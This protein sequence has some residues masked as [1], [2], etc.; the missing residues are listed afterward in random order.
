MEWK[1]RRSAGGAVGVAAIAFLLIIAMW[2]TLTA[3]N[4]PV[5]LSSFLVVVLTILSL[6]LAAW[7]GYLV[8]GYF[9]LR[10][11]LDRNA[12]IIRWA[13]SKQIIPLDQIV[14]TRK[15]REL[16]NRISK[17][18][19]FRW[20]GYMVGLGRISGVGNT[21]FY[22]TSPLR[23]Q[24]IISTSSLNYAI[25]PPD[26]EG[27]LSDLDSYRRVGTLRPL[28]EKSER[29]AF[30]DHPFWRDRTAHSLI[31]LGILVNALLFAYISWRYRGLPDLLP[32]HF[33]SQGVADIISPRDEI[34]RIPTAGLLILCV[35]LAIG[36][37][38]HRRE[39]PAAYILFGAIVATQVLL[40]IPILHTV[41]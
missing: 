18:P 7:V 33:D 8:Y 34:F 20:W 40:L 28:N 32:L 10:Y 29:S 6:S 3:L 1:P 27:F 30:A 13:S 4:N 14:E 37:L 31:G 22:A 39:R 2:F 38:A 36:A 23:G 41:H 26:I 35:N 5:S 16:S 9:T 21:L 12:L 25:S 11:S 19:R 15:G 17:S 24:V